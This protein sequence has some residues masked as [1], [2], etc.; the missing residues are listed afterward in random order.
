MPERKIG[1]I[2]EQL[3]SKTEQGEEFLDVGKFL[4]QV[5]IGELDL[6]PALDIGRL[7]PAQK[8]EIMWSLYKELQG[9]LW[10]LPN[11]RS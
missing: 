6:P 7:K 1:R 4:E 8:A 9:E 11:K 10:K 5:K 3:S 2:A